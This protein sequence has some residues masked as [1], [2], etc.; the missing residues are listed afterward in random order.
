MRPLIYSGTHRF[1]VLV[2]AACC[3]VF[4]SCNKEP[5]LKNATKTDP[6]EAGPNVRSVSKQDPW[7]GRK[8]LIEAPPAASPKPVNLPHVQRTSLSNGLLVRLVGDDSWP[9]VNLHLVVLGGTDQEPMGKR[10]L[11]DFAAQMLTKGT[12]SKTADEIAQSIDFV[13]GRLRA[14]ADLDGTHIVCQV[15]SKDLGTCLDLVPDI[16]M[17]PTFPEKEM[18]VVR[19]QLI[20]M[21]KNVRDTDRRLVGEH[22]ENLLWGEENIRGWPK[23]VKSINSIDRAE[24]VKWHNTLFKPNNAVLAI[25]GD[26]DQDK[27]VSSLAKSFGGWKR[28]QLPAFRNY[29]EPIIKGMRIRLVDKPDQTQTQIKIGHLGLEHKHPDFLA[30]S[31][32]NY[33]LGGGAFSSRLMKVV[34]AKGGK[35]YGAKSHFDEEAKRGEFWIWT[36]TRTPETVSTLKMVLDEL[37]RMRTGGPTK[38]E[39]NDAKSNLAGSYPMN[40]ETSEDVAD[41]VLT[42]ELHGLS[43]R[44]VRQYPLLLS[45]VSLQD[46]KRVAREYLHPGN[47]VIA[48]VGRAKDIEPQLK[49]AGFTYDKVGYLEPTTATERMA[50]KAK[51]TAPLDP[52]KTSLGRRLLDAALEAKGGKDKVEGIKDI[53]MEGKGSIEAA[54]QKFEVEVRGW[55]KLPDKRRLELKMPMGTVISVVS[56]EGVWAGLGTMIKPAPQAMAKKERTSLWRAGA[57]IL[58]R[59]LQQGVLV[60]ATDRVSQGGDEFDEVEIRKPDNSLSTF[61]LL[62]TKTHMLSALR[63]NEDGEEVLEEFSDYRDVDGIMM[64]YHQLRK[65]QGGQKVEMQLEKIVINKGVPEAL[66]HKPGMD[67]ESSKK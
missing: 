40:F 61:L 58:L 11:S 8:D 59:H 47:L 55:F 65:V 34:R 16:V 46:A 49:K 13:G 52:Q 23:T 1:F 22:F 60:Q 4:S 66:F 42:A 50:A 51:M 28:G 10:G 12:S 9:V 62:D 35:T 64:A 38:E 6:A 30:A 2:L 27:I 48:M 67:K 29:P 57:T 15:L 26:I 18:G 31:L 33:V 14:W 39:L 25:A 21:V 54:G 45:A 5:G 32:V 37:E 43:E 63:Y 17:H 7:S 53:Y 3:L 41:A 19:D 56:P 44:T 36:F 20:T 24:L